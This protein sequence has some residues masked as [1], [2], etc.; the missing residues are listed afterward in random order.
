MGMTWSRPTRALAVGNG[1]VINVVNDAIRVYSTS[2]A[3]LTDVVDLNSF[4][5]APQSLPP[6]VAPMSEPLPAPLPVNPRPPQAYPKTS[7]QALQKAQLLSGVEV[8]ASRRLLRPS[9]CKNAG[10]CLSSA[11]SLAAGVPSRLTPAA[12]R[13]G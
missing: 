2:G 12:A 9:P 4:P 11:R 10:I 7:D 3:P 6:P 1:Y 8:E 5:Q 13:R